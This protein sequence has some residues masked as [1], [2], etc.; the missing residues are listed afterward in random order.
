MRLFCPACGG[1]IEVHEGSAASTIVCA[2][3]ADLFI[4]GRGQPSDAGTSDS[5][6]MQALSVRP[7]RTCHTLSSDNQNAHP[8]ETPA[9]G[10]QGSPTSL[11]DSSGRG[12]CRTLWR[13]APFA[14][15]A[16]GTG[17]FLVA[18]LNA[19]HSPGPP[20]RIWRLIGLV[21]TAMTMIGIGIFGAVLVQW[22]C[23]P[24]PEE[25]SPLLRRCFALV[26]STTGI[27]LAAVL[28][29]ALP[30]PRIP[31][32]P[33]LS[34]LAAVIPAVIALASWIE[35]LTGVRIGCLRRRSESSGTRQV[36]CLLLLGM[37]LVLFPLFSIMVA[38][39]AWSSTW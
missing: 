36:G 32:V 1:E 11:H 22:Q 26:F 30:R 18:M 15:T 9:V 20:A 3:G 6:V 27:G 14:T 13:I 24:K 25:K 5:R 21:G 12:G 19:S 39:L 34:I 7:P 8:G 35:F 4:P 28:L 37:L 16:I 10:P 29:W 31:H 38:I 17:M 33:W 23:D 2:C